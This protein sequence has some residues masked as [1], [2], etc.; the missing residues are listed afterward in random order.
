VIEAIKASFSRF[1]LR[2]PSPFDLREDKGLENLRVATEPIEKGPF[3]FLAWKDK[4]GERGKG[5]N[6]DGYKVVKGA[7][8][9]RARKP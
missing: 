8:R 5:R 4:K 7:K 1:K 6:S 2:A 9:E 3:F